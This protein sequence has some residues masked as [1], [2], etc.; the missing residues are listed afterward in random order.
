MGLWKMPTGLVGAGE[1]ACEACAREVFEETG[2]EVDVGSLVAVREA[3]VKPRRKPAPNT[4]PPPSTSASS[5]STT[6]AQPT[7][8]PPQQE[9]GQSGAPSGG[10]EKCTSTNS[11]FVFLC[12]VKEGASHSELTPQPSEIAACQWMEPDA[13]LASQAKIMPPG[14]L[15]SELNRAAISAARR[16]SADAA[17]GRK[18]TAPAVGLVSRSMPMG[19][20]PGTNRVYMIEGEKSENQSVR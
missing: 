14:T 19:F 4:S 8:T 2:V 18:D 9:R 7:Q 3:H 17:A 6:S 12:T 20:R 15:Y 1:D 5:P 16:V 10:S 11:F 13:F